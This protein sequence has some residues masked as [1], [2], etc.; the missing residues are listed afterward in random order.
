MNRTRTIALL[1]AVFWCSAG[2]VQ[3]TPLISHA[4]IG[5]A[6]TG[7]HDTPDQQGLFTVA[8]QELDTAIE[9][10]EHALRA[11]SAQ[12]A[13][14][15]DGTLNALNPDRQP[16]GPGLGYGAIRALTGA[17][18][19]LEYAANSDDASSNFVA[20]VV[21]LVDE[22]DVVIARMLDAQRILESLDATKPVDRAE[23]ARVRDLLLAAK[24]GQN[25]DGAIGNAYLS[26]G[27]GLEHI[28]AEL[29]AMLG[30]ETD[31]SYQ[32][33][34]RKYVLGLVRLPNGLWAYRLP[35]RKREP[36]SYGY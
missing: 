27:N 31:P 35:R 1:G 28:A 12:A 21:D 26:Y 3:T 8:R 34:P 24:F 29:H 18:E 32:P 13:P 9:S 4:H 11:D 22:G 30:R 33:V 5:H 7:W 19:H 2:C 6:L 15:L 20:S 36:I 14:Y 17:I 16:L 25:R 10:A 23:I